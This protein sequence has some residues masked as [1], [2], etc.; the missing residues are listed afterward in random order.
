MENFKVSTVKGNIEYSYNGN[1]IV[2]TAYEE[3]L[4]VK[5][6]P[7]TLGN[8]WYDLFEDAIRSFILNTASNA[9]CSGLHSIMD[10]IISASKRYAK[11][12]NVTIAEDK[13]KALFIFKGVLKDIVTGY[14]SSKNADRLVSY[15]HD[16]ICAAIKL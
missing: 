16:G 8:D 6:N 9:S 14:D 7:S 1:V 4:K 5:P 3:F 13:Y 2:G 12:Y 11:L 15:L 10:D